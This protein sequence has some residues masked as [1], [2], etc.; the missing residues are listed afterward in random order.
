VTRY[1]ERLYA[2]WWWYPVGMAAGFILG[3]EIG[4]S[5]Y[6]VLAAV[7]A[8]VLA[9][10]AFPFLIGRRLVEVRDGELRTGRDRVPVAGLGPPVLRS[11]EGLRRRLGPEGD[12]VAK[13]CYRWWIRD[14]VEFPTGGGDGYWLVSTRR[15]TELAAAVE[16][17]RATSGSRLG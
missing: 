9:A 1:R 17:E 5:F 14:A 16:A 12:P 8:L 2:P 10:A 4:L 6:V 13:V 3:F 11:G 7:V 15:P